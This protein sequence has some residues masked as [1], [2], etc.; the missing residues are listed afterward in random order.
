MTALA[1]A[2]LLVVRTYE[3]GGVA[4][5]DLDT[6][7]RIAGA[8]LGQAG[9]SAAWLACPAG[10]EAWLPK[11]PCTKAPRPHEVLVRFASSDRVRGVDDGVL[12][13][14][15]VDAGAG[16]GSLA[17]LY[18]DRIDAI[19]ARAGVAVGVV[20]GRAMAHEI[21]H[22]LLGHSRHRDRGLM[23]AYWSEMVLRSGFA[24][25]WTFLPEDARAMARN[26][27]AREQGRE[28]EMRRPAQD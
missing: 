12:G 5:S 1:L 17:T 19:A 27:A 18:I 4:A 26:L 22:L 14:A 20:L 8:I 9:V 15:L 25:D 11:P 24:G 10:T 13:N 16:A 23:R 3:G 6:S 28:I 2:L 7:R 21:G